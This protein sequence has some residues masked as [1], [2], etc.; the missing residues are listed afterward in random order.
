ML[1]LQ[2]S[3]WHW[4]QTPALIVFG[5]VPGPPCAGFFGPWHCSQPTPASMLSFA[6][7]VVRSE[8]YSPARHGVH[9]V[10]TKPTAAATS[11]Q[12]PLFALLL[13]PVVWQEKHDGP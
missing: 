2:G 7:S 1:C 12:P 5:C 11:S 3:S 8:S 6:L 10:S 13:K 4:A 9:C